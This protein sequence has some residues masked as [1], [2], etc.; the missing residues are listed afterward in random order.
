MSAKAFKPDKTTEFKPVKIDKINAAWIIP[1][2]ISSG[3]TIL[4]L[5]G[6]GFIAGSINSHRDIASRLAKA[7]NSKL[8]II[9]YRLAP[10]HPF[11]AGLEDALTAYR[12]LLEN[13]VEHNKI[14]LAGD[15]A[16][17]GLT[18]AL[19][20]KIKLSKLPLPDAA[21]FF[22]PWTDLENKNRSFKAN[23]GIDPMLNKNMLEQTAALY[24]NKKDL[25]N[26]LVSPINSDLTGLCPMLIHVGENEVLLDDSLLLAQYAKKAGVKT[27]IEVFD[28]MFHVFQYFAKYLSIAR[29]SINKAGIFIQQSPES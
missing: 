20:A 28:N 19:L 24:C 8:L 9:D 26:P 1:K 21:V 14:A 25:S 16:G 18:L 3:K 23:E 7:S 11:P 22:S 6:G 5:H 4:F 27:T 17:G 2:N 12:W 10:E 15:S 13:C 29:A